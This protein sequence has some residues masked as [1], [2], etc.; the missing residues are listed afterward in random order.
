[1]VIF[2]GVESEEEFKT[3]RPEEYQRVAAQ[4][5]LE[6]RLAVQPPVW[7]LNFSKAVGYTAIFIGLLLLVL[8][9]SAYFGS[10]AVRHSRREWTIIAQHEAKR[11]AGNVGQRGIASRRAATKLSLRTKPPSCDCP[12]ADANTL[13]CNIAQDGA[14]SRTAGCID[15]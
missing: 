3:K 14:D 7:L 9:L 10:G 1:M 13:R 5:K 12:E 4:G 15:D 11:N 8:T 2:T 6:S